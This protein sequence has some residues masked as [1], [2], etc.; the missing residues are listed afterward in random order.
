MKI[1]LDFMVKIHKKGWIKTAKT[2]KTLLKAANSLT[3]NVFSNKIATD[4]KKSEIYKGNRG[5]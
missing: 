1:I 2:A 3:K 5:D 4:T